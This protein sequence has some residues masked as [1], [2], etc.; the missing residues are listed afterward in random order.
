MAVVSTGISAGHNAH[1]DQ[2]VGDDDPVWVLTFAAKAI[3]TAP[4][5]GFGVGARLAKL[6]KKILRNA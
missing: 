2:R 4:L 6:K 1:K 5:L 3:M